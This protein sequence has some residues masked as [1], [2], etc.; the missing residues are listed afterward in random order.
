MATVVCP[1]K[2]ATGS[3]PSVLVR[4][5]YPIHFIPFSP[6]RFSLSSSTFGIFLT[7][8][9]SLG[10]GTYAWAKKYDTWQNSKAAHLAGHEH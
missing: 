4:T 9:L 2:L 7:I 5:H 8:I 3:F 10:Y 6:S 1:L